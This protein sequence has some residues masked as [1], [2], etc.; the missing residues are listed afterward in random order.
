MIPILCV[1]ITI[2]LV[3]WSPLSL[4]TRCVPNKGKH[5][6]SGKKG[7]AGRGVP[8]ATRGEKMLALRRS[9][10]AASPPFLR[11]GFR[12]F[13][14][15]AAVWAVIAL[16][17]WMAFLIH[18][19]QPPTAFGLLAWH[20]HE[21]VFGF[22]GAVIAGFLLT[23]I[24]NWT[25]H[26]PIAGL[27]LL[28]L[29]LLWAGGRA[30]VLCSGV[31]GELPAAIMDVSFPIVLTILAGREI[32]LAKNRNLPVLL[33]LAVF[34]AANAADHVEAAGFLED[35]G[36][37]IRGGITLVI[38]MISL[39]GGR[40]LPSFTRNWMTKHGITKGLPQQPGRYDLATIGVSG[41]ALALWTFFP[42]L[43]WVGLLLLAAAG[44]QLVRLIRWSG[45]KTVADPLVF[46]L[47]LGY[48]WI[49]LGLAGLGLA[50]LGQFLPV[51][52]AV[53]MLTAGGM[54]TMVLAVMTRASLGHTGR[55]LRASP[56]TV[57]IYALV[58]VGALLRV[59]GPVFLP[60]PIAALELAAL[61]W[62]AAFALFAV[63][64]G[65][66]LFSPRCDN[67]DL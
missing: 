17:V 43:V 16:T 10:M 3:L 44:M 12:P 32:V 20:R 6:M 40:I 37:P 2:Y 7:G 5:E 50:L 31:I 25:G 42:E 63:V 13:F 57:V 23:A 22:L 62:G 67:P 47:H 9:R 8:V 29:F 11:G 55:P 35:S 38:L 26:L 51:S 41:A 30:A 46:V 36:V 24:P 19:F 21:M 1:A 56:S 27:P 59:F 14:W 15:G 64:Y 58:T 4:P 60:E 53:H 28:L 48:A 34:G 54:A 18:G 33:L 65:Q 45:W 66:I 39:I 49:P 52:S 61:F